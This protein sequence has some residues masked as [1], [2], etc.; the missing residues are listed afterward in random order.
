MTLAI[1][2]KDFLRTVVE[3]AELHGWMVHHVLEQA[4]HA[5]RIGPGFP[6]LVLA[7][8]N[9]VV[10]A[11]LKA[12]KGQLSAVQQ[13]WLAVLR[14]VRGARTF[15]WRPSDWPEIEK[16]LG[17]YHRPGVAGGQA[18]PRHVDPELRRRSW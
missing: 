9:R 13:E 17:E 4:H 7:K 1:A 11:E 10:F 5:K 15:L 3:Y 6:D 12:E 8:R 14:T 16:V 18:P 2:E